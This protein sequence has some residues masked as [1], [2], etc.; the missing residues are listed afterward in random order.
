MTDLVCVRPPCK[1]PHLTLA[2]RRSR[3]APRS[4]PS[5]TARAELQRCAPA[6]GRADPAR[7]SA[8]SRWLA[9]QAASRRM[10][11]VRARCIFRPVRRS[12]RTGLGIG[13]QFLSVFAKGTPKQLFVQGENVF[14][15]YSLAN[16][17]KYFSSLPALAS[18]GCRMSVQ[19]GGSIH[20]SVSALSF[21]SAR[22]AM[23][24][25]ASKLSRNNKSS[26]LLGSVSVKGIH[27]FSTQASAVGRSIH[28]LAWN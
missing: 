18:T 13:F 24:A 2:R 26:C 7:G 11:L 1:Q 10:L 6:R 9:R 27:T 15:V 22:S 25:C 4:L 17:Y 16:P 19:P 12:R 8:E 21:S 5:T 3:L 28:A 23:C 20:A 14:K